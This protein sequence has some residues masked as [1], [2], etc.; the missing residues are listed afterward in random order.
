MALAHLAVRPHSRAKGQ[1]AA[2][3][4]AY[5]A[6]ARLRNSRTGEIHDFRSR[7]SGAVRD[8]IHATPPG[9]SPAWNLDDLQSWADAIEGA[10]RRKNSTILRD[11]EV[12][13]PHELNEPARLS[14][15]QEWATWLS[16]RYHTPV[17]V[18]LHAA[19]SHGDRRNEHMHCVL[20][21]RD[22]K[23]DGFFGAKL[24]ELDDWKTGRQE[25][26]RYAR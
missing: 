20:P 9:V 10:E 11:V 8:T 4:I 1:S 24:R 5:R 3:A 6:G 21:T 23:P 15:A 13:L 25:I 19:P 7:R 22:L 16:T 12:S 18:S 17:L 14:L 2:A 26:L